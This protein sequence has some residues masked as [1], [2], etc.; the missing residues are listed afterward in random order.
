MAIAMP[1]NAGKSRL[2]VNIAAYT[3]LVHQKKG[4]NNIK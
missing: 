1:S 4:I 2:T 3:A